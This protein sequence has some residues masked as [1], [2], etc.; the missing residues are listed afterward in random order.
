M[1]HDF[2]ERLISDG[3]RCF[4]LKEGKECK[5]NTDAIELLAQADR[6]ILAWGNKGSHTFDVAKAEATSLIEA[7]EAAFNSFTCG[8]CKKRVTFA[9]VGD[10][11]VQCECSEL[12]WRK[13]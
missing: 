9:T 13:N 1:A 2:L 4:K 10:D 3:R 12:Q 8:A 7:C 6:R 11:R 5:P